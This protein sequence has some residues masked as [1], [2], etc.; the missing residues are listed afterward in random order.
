MNEGYGMIKACDGDDDG[1]H[2]S[3]GANGHHGFWAFIVSFFFDFDGLWQELGL[4]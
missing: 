2:G 1:F 4:R 3:E